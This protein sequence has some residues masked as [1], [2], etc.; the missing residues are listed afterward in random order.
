MQSL[1]GGVYKMFR[2]VLKFMSTVAN[3]VS[4]VL[5]DTLNGNTKAEA[6]GQPKS[7]SSNTLP[8]HPPLSPDHNSKNE[9]VSIET[10]KLVLLEG[11]LKRGYTMIIMDSHDTVGPAH[12]LSTIRALM[13]NVPHDSIF[14]MTPS[15]KVAYATGLNNSVYVPTQADFDISRDSTDMYIC[16]TDPNKDATQMRGIMNKLKSIGVSSIEISNQ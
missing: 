7:P 13:P 1:N 5:H 8:S 6:S 3:Q 11:Y 4:L 2:A 9:P 14:V 12:I 16:M 15:L 10:V